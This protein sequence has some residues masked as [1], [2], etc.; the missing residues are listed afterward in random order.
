MSALETS[1]TKS[2]VSVSVAL[3]LLLSERPETVLYTDTP[4]SERGERLAESLATP[5]QCSGLTCSHVHEKQ[6]WAHSQR[7]PSGK[8][9]PRGCQACYFPLL[10]PLAC[11]CGMWGQ[12]V[13][14][15]YPYRGMGHGDMRGAEGASMCGS[16]HGAHYTANQ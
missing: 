5:V 14:Y 7:L 3:P 10:L 16:D 13:V 8:L 15:I 4:R 2:S 1:Q 11:Q 12:E 9:Q 6:N